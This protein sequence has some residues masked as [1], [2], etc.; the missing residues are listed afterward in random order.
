MS[1]NHIVGT[2]KDYALDSITQ[3]D[4]DGVEIA[5]VK[6]AEGFFAVSDICTHAEVSLSDGSLNGCLL[7]CPMHGAEFDIKTGEAKSLPATKPL[8]VYKVLVSGTD[9]N[10]TVSIEVGK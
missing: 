8:E 7:E 2:V 9:E 6:T 3:I 1:N 5:L 4:I 10:A